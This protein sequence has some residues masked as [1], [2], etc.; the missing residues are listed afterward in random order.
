MRLSD[1]ELAGEALLWGIDSHNR[2]AHVGLSLL[3][4]LRGVGLGKDAVMV[5]CHY[6]FKTLGLHR[7][8]LE[9]LVENAPMIRVA[10]YNGFRREGIRRHA[11]W[12]DGDYA[13]EL[14][15]GLLASDWAE[16]TT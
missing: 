7:L 12:V 15:L 6:G 3:P 4:R 9:T 13:D 11:A 2:S 16:A 1:D 5:L 14:T 10:T 8:Q